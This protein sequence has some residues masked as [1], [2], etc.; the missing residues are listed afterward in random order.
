MGV[1]IRFANTKNGNRV[2]ITKKTDLHH[3]QHHSDP[4]QYV[5]AFAGSNGYSGNLEKFPTK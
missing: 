3:K 2:L 4:S 1:M 5:L